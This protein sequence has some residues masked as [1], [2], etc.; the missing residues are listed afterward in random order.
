[1]PGPH[2]DDASDRVVIHYAVVF[3]GVTPVLCGL[4][5][6][7]A[8]SDRRYVSCARCRALLGVGPVEGDSG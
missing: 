3:D 6:E 1:M 2:I 5:H 4:V 7:P 8:M